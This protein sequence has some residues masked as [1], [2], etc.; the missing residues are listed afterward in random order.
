MN[1]SDSSLQVLF[2][3]QSYIPLVKQDSYMPILQETINSINNQ[4]ITKEIKSHIVLSDDGSFYLKK[5]IHNDINQDIRILN[6]QEVQ[7]I[8]EAY[9]LNVDEV[10]ITP[11]SDLF[12]KASLFNFYLKNKGSQFDLV[13][14][15]DDDHAFVR[16]D[17]VSK[18]V[19]YYREGYNFIVGRLYLSKEGFYDFNLGVQGTTY[20]ISYSTLKLIN[21]FNESIKEWGFGEDHDIFYRIYLEYLNS[22][23]NAVYDSNIVTVDKIS[24]RWL[25]CTNKIGG[26]EL[27]RNKFKEKYGVS[28]EDSVVPKSYWMKII[29]ND[30]GLKES[31]FRYLAID[32]YLNFKKLSETYK[33]TIILRIIKRKVF[34]KAR[35]L[36]IKIKS[37]LIIWIKKLQR[38]YFW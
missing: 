10:M 8:R 15:L 4:Q 24:G 34:S 16:N 17:S 3:I 22:R 9:G 14:F 35:S 31:Y 23:I 25:Y 18:F 21:F 7:E 5:Y 12:K 20:A 13:V 29:S 6:I 28:M 37:L 33:K 19:Q 1:Y 36:L 2:L 38:L 32:E 26:S 11:E 30:L 27:G